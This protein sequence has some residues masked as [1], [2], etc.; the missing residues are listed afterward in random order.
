MVDY[1]QPANPMPNHNINTEAICR[2]CDL[3]FSSKCNLKRHVLI[4][5]EAISRGYHRE[6]IEELKK[7]S[8]KKSLAQKYYKSNEIGSGKKAFSKC[9]M[10]LYWFSRAEIVKHLW[11]C[12]AKR[13][14]LNRIIEVK[15]EIKEEVTMEY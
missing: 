13:P 4:C 5:K 8:L 11:K 12:K 2:G 14:C 3:S 15:P 7:K 9:V 6:I 10:C 1:C